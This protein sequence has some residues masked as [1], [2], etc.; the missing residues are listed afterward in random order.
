MFFNLYNNFTFIDGNGINKIID[1]LPNVSYYI[2]GNV[3]VSPV[4]TITVINLGNEGVKYCFKCR[5]KY[6]DYRKKILQSYLIYIKI[7]V[8]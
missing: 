1:L 2:N 7:K 3:V 6:F 5:N 4:P 8:F